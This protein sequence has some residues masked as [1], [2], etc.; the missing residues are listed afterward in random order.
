MSDSPAPPPSPRPRRRRRLIWLAVG[1]VV[2][3]WC[4]VAGLQLV[5]ARRHAQRGL[6]E[7]QSVKD[8]LGPAELIRGKGLGRMR[9]A[10][11][12]FDD[13]ASAGDSFLLKPFLVLPVIGRQV[14]S[15]SALT[16]SA[17][18]VVQVGTD[19][20]SE[21]TKKL[22]RPTIAGPDRV[23][24]VR[25]LG[26]VA[27]K[28]RG[29]LR[30][31][32]L[33]PGEALLGPLRDARRKFGRQLGKIRQ[34]MIDVDEASKGVAQMAQGPSKYLVLASNNS[35]MRA[36][37]GM[38]LSAGV[39]TLQDG[40]F[41]LGPMTDTG[42]L[43]VPAGAVPLGTNDFAKRW[44]WADPSQ[45]WRNLAMSPTFP[46][47]AALAAQMWKAKTGQQ[48]DGVFAIDP[49][50]LQALIKVSGP[51]TVGGKLITKDNVIHETLLQSYLDYEGYQGDPGSLQSGT[52]ARRER[53][54]DIA[55]AVIDQL[56]QQGWDVA[57]L[58]DELQSAAQGRHVMA[59]SSIPQQ[60]RGWQGAGISGR[61]RAD[62][63]LVALQNRGGNKLDQ[64][65]GVIASIEHRPVKDGS[66]VTVH[67]NVRN[68]TPTEGL[69]TF[70]EG[71]FP[72]SGF[73]AGQ[74]HG[75]L[76]VNV[77]G[78]AGDVRLE[79]GTKIVTA[80]R[81]AKTYVIATEMDLFRGE[82]KQFVLHFRLP[83]GYEHLTVEP[84]ARYPAIT[85]TAG[86]KP[87]MDNSAR[88]LSW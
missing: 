42:E 60:E 73:V 65:L 11:S 86:G 5:Q 17:A 53:S 50:G 84:S 21:S 61:L 10:E 27:A 26:G 59:W 14:R 28:A 55:R 71:P 8:N 87:W 30:H 63:L 4:V 79:G 39:M 37:S 48:V 69:N 20:M 16:G 74:Y 67:I 25:E 54:S 18:K 47:S 66:E 43:L 13:A 75:I 9:A 7:L 76:S 35:E 38:L 57:K 81:D 46:A 36:G 31:V 34:S 29:Q 58:V 12:E 3:I 24:L 80:G 68:D 23:A 85:W 88:P 70:V 83:G 56:D 22:D 78:V 2:V 62:S 45:E 64:F 52:A 32:D 19:A 41:D 44:G 77:P 40:Q 33:G 51:V 49:L 82:Q 72:Q 1:I 6:D 15:V